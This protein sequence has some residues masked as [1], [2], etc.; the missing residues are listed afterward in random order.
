MSENKATQ[1]ASQIGI[2]NRYEHIEHDTIKLPSKG[3]FYPKD[4]DGKHI[5]HLRVAYLTAEDENI[6]LSPN[7][8]SSG[9]MI[10]TLLKTKII[11]ARIDPDDLL[12]GD[13]LAILFWLRSTGISNEYKVMLTDEN[14]K[15]F[16]HEFDLSQMEYNKF[17]ETIINEDGTINGSVD[18]NGKPFRFRFR[19]LTHR[20]Y[21]QFN[22]EMEAKSKVVKR[23]YDNTITTLISRKIVELDGTTDRGEIETQYPKLRMMVAKKIR[24]FMSSQ[25]PTVITEMEVRT[26]SGTFREYEIP[27]TGDFFYPE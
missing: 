10:D 2:D 25:E 9:E 27:I 21:N 22:K 11:D 26:P 4:S 19:H 3:L 15:P 18:V 13:R 24:E 6:M 16:E 12:E 23:K 8:V 17:D 20:E 5:T 14:G 1:S 7:L